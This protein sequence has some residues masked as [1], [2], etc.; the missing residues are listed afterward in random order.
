[1]AVRNVFQNPFESI[2]GIA[3]AAVPPIKKAVKAV[4]QDAKQ[5]LTGEYSAQNETPGGVKEIPVYEQKQ[6]EDD[7]KRLLDETR[8]RLERINAD[9]K[10]AREQR[11]S[12]IQQKE[13]AKAQEKQKKEFEQKKKDEDP[14]WKKM[15]KGKTGSREAGRGSG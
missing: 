3:K 11:L 15:L 5:Q 1:M 12:K 4:V 13:Q 8:M 10:R 6:I 2:E 7:S 14:A 9:I